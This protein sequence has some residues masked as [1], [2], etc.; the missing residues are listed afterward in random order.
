MGNTDI[1]NHFFIAGATR[2]FSGLGFTM[3]ALPFSA[4]Y[5]PVTVLVPIL[6]LLELIGNGQMYP[7]I[8]R[9]VDWPWLTALIVPTVLFTAL[10][11]YLL[12]VLDQEYV[13]FAINVFILFSVIW[14]NIGFTFKHHPGIKGHLMFGSVAG[15]MNGVAAMSG[16]SVSTYALA[17]GMPMH[18]IR[19]SLIMFFILADGIGFGFTVVNGLVSLN[20]VYLALLFYFPSLLGNKLGERLFLRFGNEK[21]KPFIIFLLGII[22]LTSIVQFLFALI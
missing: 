18:V 16:P 1:A 11:V 22:S 19:A 2:G 3:V 21:G 13:V 20:A 9:D 15:I 17:L 12:K 10:G 6:M 7:K 14:I 8:K 4:H 5:V